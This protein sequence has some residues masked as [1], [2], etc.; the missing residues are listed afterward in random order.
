MK[1]KIYLLLIS[2]CFFMF[3]DMTHARWYGNTVRAVNNGNCPVDA[4]PDAI[5][6]VDGDLA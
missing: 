4:S 5:G 3:S 2:I 1:T 6:P